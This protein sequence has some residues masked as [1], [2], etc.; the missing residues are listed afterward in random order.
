MRDCFEKLVLMSIEG[1]LGDRAA[2]AHQVR[3]LERERFAVCSDYFGKKPSGWIVRC[4]LD[5]RQLTDT[6]N[7]S[8]QFPALRHQVGVRKFVRG[9]QVPGEAL[10]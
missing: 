2:E 10:V 9:I 7:V 3:K 5:Q 4:A 6:T 8:Q 1:T